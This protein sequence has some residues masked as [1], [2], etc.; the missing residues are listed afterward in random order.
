MILPEPSRRELLH[1][2]RVPVFAFLA[3]LAMLRLILALDALVP[4]RTASF[5]KFGILICMVR[6]VVL[7]SM[8][9][10]SEPPLMRLF[11]GLGFGWVVILGGVTIL[12][13]LTR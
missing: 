3:R 8:E 7:F 11:A 12:D 9:V 6:T 5:I 2:I 13:Y 1:H 4:S 10:P